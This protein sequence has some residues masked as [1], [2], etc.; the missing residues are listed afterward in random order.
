[1]NPM[2]GLLSRLARTPI[3]RQL[4]L[5]AALVVTITALLSG[6]I[7]VY[8]EYRGGREALL[9]D[10]QV[11]ARMIAANSS[12]ALVFDD[13][14]AAGEILQA[15]SASENVLAA[16]LLGADGKLV[17]E[18]RA[19]L[20]A[21]PDAEL[22][23]VSEPVR[24][25]GRAY[26]RLVIDAHLSRLNHR[27][28]IYSLGVLTV[29]IVAVTLALL[30]FSR[31]WDLITRPVQELTALMQQ[32][33]SDGDYSRRSGIDSSNEIG[34]IAR[35]F[36]F[37]LGEI[38]LRQRAL[39]SELQVRVRT[40]AAL[41]HLVHHDVL[42]QL[43]NR[44]ALSERMKT[45]A[46]R[47]S[48]KQPHCGLVLLDLDNFKLVNDTLGHQAGDELLV[49][50]AAR[51]REMT[52]DSVAI[53]RLG[54]DEFATLLFGEG[55]QWRC[56]QLSDRLVE[57]T[58]P[59]FR[60]DDHE[61][62]VTVS[63]G[64]AVY[65]E[66]ASELPQLLRH[67]DLALYAAK[68]QGRN[69]WR[70]FTPELQTVAEQR[71]RLESDLR[72]ALERREFHLVYEPQVDLASGRLRGVEALLRWQH[73]QRGLVSPKDFIPLAEETDLIVPIGKWV[74]RQACE[75]GKRLLALGL[76]EE[77]RL[78]INLAPRQLSEVD[79]VATVASTL[80]ET[81]FPARHL[82]LEVTESVMTEC[83]DLVAERMHAI[84]GSG[85]SF[86]LD[87]FGAGAS[88]LSYL[89]RLPL[90][91]LKIDRGFVDDIPGSTSDCEV[92]AAIIAVGARLGLL[93][94]A[95]GVETAE[96][97]AF[98]RSEGCAQAQG[99]F[100]ARP[101]PLEAF[102][103]DWRARLAAQGAGSTSPGASDQGGRAA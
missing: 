69:T 91:K 49:K 39:T 17:A 94:L 72:R 68:N 77:F 24:Y 64:F 84:A 47:D 88:S 33:A 89:R 14:Q 56:R 27:L 73:P 41:D 53:F 81:G 78:A 60:I 1:M 8:I 66:Q 28:L 59:P 70:P 57:G 46:M 74:M 11:Q 43:G 6:A 93:V 92:A 63:A 80:A 62:F 87:D 36:D 12:A 42:T 45:V 48:A 10:L 51:L 20:P 7:T 22:L 71:M 58:R 2:A 95:E 65:P 15:L 19:R 29:L 18:Y 79:I 86:A 102:L 38:E 30:L 34:D 100:F 16:R 103:A 99:Y 55:L 97:L 25:Q 96:Q 9:S 50:F 13:V 26:G 40:Q 21:R 23:Q 67:A 90:R 35:S 3:R 75:D 61:V 54:G 82:E 52:D 31:L 4:S 83:I 98:L 101:Q 76:G 44:H 32:V 5:G 85:V 37:M